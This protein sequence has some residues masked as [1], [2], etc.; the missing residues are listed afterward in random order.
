MSSNEQS[1]AATREPLRN[2]ILNEGFGDQG[3]SCLNAEISAG[4][5]L[6]VSGQESA[7]MCEAMGEDLESQVWVSLA[8]DWKDEL[9]L[10]LSAERFKSSREL[11][12]FLEAH[13]IPASVRSA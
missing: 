9:L 6:V 10:R 7:P 8:P 11:L 2:L 13:G 12:D 3:S 5:G 4:G 1:P